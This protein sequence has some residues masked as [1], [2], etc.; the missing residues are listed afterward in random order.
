MTDIKAK[1]TDD[2]VIFPARPDNSLF[3][4][5]FLV[6]HALSVGSLVFALVIGVSSASSPQ[7]IAIAACIAIIA[8]VVL[9]IGVEIW[10]KSLTPKQSYEGERAALRLSSAGIEGDAIDRQK[11]Q[12]IDWS[13][14]QAA[15]VYANALHIKFAPKNLDSD[16]PADRISQVRITGG[17]DACPVEMR[18][19]VIDFSKSLG[20]DVA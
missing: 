2:L 8:A 3:L 12:R 18:D 5:A 4:K 7:A 19:A 17:P 6:F 9:T 14:F 15:E 13:Q 1:Q 10:R 20:H 16:N 11:I